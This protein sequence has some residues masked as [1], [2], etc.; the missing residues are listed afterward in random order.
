MTEFVP[1]PLEELATDWPPELDHISASSVKMA[2][3]CPE[4]WRQRYVLG[5]K[6]PP[7]AALVLGRA[8]H[9]AVEHSMVQKQTSFVDLPVTEVKDKFIAV[10]D[11]EIDRD[12]GYAE[13]EV[14]DGKEQIR[15]I[16]KKK[17]V[18]GE[19]KRAGGMR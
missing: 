15:A 16:A 6:T 14:R 8:D 2:A 9:A 3:R 11:D 13:L 17:R 1:R 7:A 12:G 18:V 5:R 10:V 19:M 4:Q